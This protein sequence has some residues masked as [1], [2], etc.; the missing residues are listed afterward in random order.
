METNTKE[1]KTETLP[2]SLNQ[3]RAIAARVFEDPA[4][5]GCYIETAFGEVRVVRASEPGQDHEIY[6]DRIA[7]KL[8]AN[9]GHNFRKFLNNR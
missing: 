8:E 1:N 9:F 6:M 4:A 3:V 5:T 7:D 2:N